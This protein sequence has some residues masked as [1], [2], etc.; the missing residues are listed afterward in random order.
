VQPAGR[1]GY[2]RFDDPRRVDSFEE[3]PA[4]EGGWVN[5]GFFVLSPKVIDYIP[6][7]Q[8]PWERRPLAAIVAGGQL[9]AYQHSGFWQCMDTLRDKTHLEELWQNGAPWKKW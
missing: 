3:K 1:F 7:D 5:G 9:A 8:E 6:D 4:G 2:L